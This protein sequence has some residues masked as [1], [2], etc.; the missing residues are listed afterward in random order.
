MTIVHTYFDMICKVTYY[1]R[2]LTVISTLLISIMSSYF[3]FQF[4]FV[5]YRFLAKGENES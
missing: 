2:I 4:S 1:Y 3:F 5:M